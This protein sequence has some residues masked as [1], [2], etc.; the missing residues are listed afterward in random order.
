M[1]SFAP[2][3][4]LPL[5]F[6][7]GAFALGG[8]VTNMS[9]A[10]ITRAQVFFQSDSTVRQFTDT[11][12]AFTLAA[13][14]ALFGQ[15]RN[16]P[17][18]QATDGLTV[19]DG[20]LA[21][22]LSAAVRTGTISV[23]SSGG[24]KRFGA[25]VA[26]LGAGA[27]ELALPRLGSGLYFARF[28]LDG[29]TADRQLI[30]TSGTEAKAQSVVTAPAPRT[31]AASTAKTAAVDTLIIRR[32]GYV[33]KKV[34]VTSYAQTGL[35]VALSPDTVP[36]QPNVTDYSVNGPFATTIQ[37][38]VGPENNY[39]IIRPVT[40]GANGFRHPPIIYGHGINSQ[41]STF[42]TFLSSVASHGFVII[43]RNV[44]TGGPNN[45]G[46]TSAMNN[47]LNWILA[48]DTTPGSIYF[49]KLATDRAAAMG[50]SVGGTAAVD[51]G[52]HPALQTVVSIHGHISSV[53]LNGTLLQTSGTLDNVGLPMQQTTYGNSKVQTF[54]G[55]VTGANHGYIQ[56]NNGG[57]QRA[58]IIAWL[59][60]W[61]Y[62]DQG[63]RAYFYGPT[64]TLCAPV[65]ENPQRKYWN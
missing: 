31:F 13:P 48:Q 58:A 17:A 37:A 32:I 61:L 25:S 56:S 18:T 42:T 3:L 46:N 5:V 26:S 53:I 62:N 4:A 28:T 19:R 54:L 60:L 12:G 47:G 51:I 38:N 39:T 49:G 36:L 55:T 63:G 45:A 64:C 27:H 35:A 16:G 59:R 14:T 11:T 34:A 22:S 8:S 2:L 1:K 41:V 43:A 21:F 15:T 7:P 57:V 33:S 50:Y 24:A 10:I 30:L 65:W 9:G 6:A 52:N 44:L 40:L 29:Q 23:F 20:R